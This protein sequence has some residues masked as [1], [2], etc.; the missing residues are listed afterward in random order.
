MIGK[1]IR[2]DNMRES[3]TYQAVLEEGREEALRSRVINLL[4]MGVAV[5]Q[6]AQA[7]GM[8]IKAI[9]QLGRSL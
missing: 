5:D 8:S 2:R 9:N 7:S 6:I 1:I 4:R 3:V